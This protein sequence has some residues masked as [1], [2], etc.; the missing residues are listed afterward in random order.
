[1]SFWLQKAAESTHVY[2]LALNNEYAGDFW[3]SIKTRVSLASIE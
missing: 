2:S 1:M 3:N